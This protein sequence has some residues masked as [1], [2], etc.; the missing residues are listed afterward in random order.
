[1]KQSLIEI[2]ENSDG[3]I[4][5][6]YLPA[7]MKVNDEVETF[8]IDVPDLRVIANELL[9]LADGFDKEAGEQH[10]VV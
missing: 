10:E 3:R 4:T 5:I 1:M 6:T 2:Y 8:E 9:R 7:D